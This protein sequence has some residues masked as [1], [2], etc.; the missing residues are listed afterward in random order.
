MSKEIILALGGGGVRGIAHLGVLSWLEEHGYTV[1]AI[2]GTSAGGIFGAAYAAGNPVKTIIQEVDT[3]LLKPDFRRESGDQPSLI[4]TAGLVN[5]L[6][7]L[8]GDKN[9]EDF[10]IEFAAT[11]VSLKTGQEIILTHGNALEAV[12]ATIAVPGIFPSRG[13]D[14]MLVDGGVLDPVPVAVAR[15]FNTSLPVVAVAL[16]RKQGSYS[17]PH[18]HLPLAGPIPQNLFDRVSR[19]RMIG[20]LQVF[21][22][23]IELG[24]DSIS[25]MN[26]IINKPDVL[27]LPPLGNIG[28]LDKVNADDLVEVGYKAME[29]EEAHL[30]E[31]LNLLKTFRR[32]TQY[33]VARD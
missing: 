26:L 12:L 7:P 22:S 16:N 21:F 23:S 11:T 19:T 8:I 29:A 3:F 31:S 30:A 14:E 33:T 27:V 18:L 2:A 4:G 5:A 17:P 24:S 32:I 9:I 20:A 15:R 25:E 13:G 6:K 10:P 28:I 1:K